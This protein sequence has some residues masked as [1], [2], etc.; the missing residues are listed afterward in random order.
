MK[1]LYQMKTNIRTK[2]LIALGAPAILL[3]ANLCAQTYNPNTVDDY[4]L[5]V[6]AGTNALAVEANGMV[7][8]SSTNTANVDI[9]PNSI[10]MTNS[11]AGTTVPD[12]TDQGNSNTLFDINRF[13]AIANATTHGY[14]PSGNNHFTNL[15]TFASEVLATSVTNPMEGIIVVDV[16]QSDPDLNVFQSQGAF[17][18]GINVEGCLVFN[19]VGSG[20]SANSGKIVFEN[21]VN[22]NAANLTNLNPIDPS[23]YTSGYPP[24]YTNSYVNPANI[25]ISG[26]TDPTTGRPYQNFTSSDDLPAFIYTIGIVDLHDGLDICGAMYTPSYAEIENMHAGETQYIRGEI[27]TG[28][29]IFVQ[30]QQQAITVISYDPNAVKNL[31]TSGSAAK[32]AVVSYWQ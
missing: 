18:N 21:P 20:W 2:L 31:A 27:I 19:F 8:I 4:A 16:S 24:V 5:V 30:N 13:I 14:A 9:P 23:T 25:D 28:Y 10:S 6:Y 11:E 29:G 15:T 1:V 17:P 22:V 26:Q 3:A 12:Y 7:N 32:K